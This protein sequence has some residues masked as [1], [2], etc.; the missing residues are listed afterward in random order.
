M[1]SHLQAVC[2]LSL[3]TDCDVCFI[4][5]GVQMLLKTSK[6]YIF[7]A[8]LELLDLKIFPKPLTPTSGFIHGSNWGLC[9]RPL[10]YGLAARHDV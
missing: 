6:S 3:Y 9:P 10:L 4:N 5:G 1:N 2:A 7:T 8:E